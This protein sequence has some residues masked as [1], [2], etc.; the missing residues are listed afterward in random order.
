MDCL[1][2]KLRS[3]YDITLAFP[4]R[5]VQNE[6][7]FAS[8]HRPQ[9][10]CFHVRRYDV[11]KDLPPVSNSDELQKWLIDRWREK[12]EELQ[13]F[14]ESDTRRLS[15]DRL[16]PLKPN[17]RQKIFLAFS[18]LFWISLTSLWIY[19]LC[20]F[21]YMWLYVLT[22]T[23]TFIIIGRIFGGIERLE[24]YIWKS[25]RKIA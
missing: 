12:E 1:E 7:Q 20:A 2:K 25:R 10:L 15:S 13:K 19:W 16:R 11:E 6:L 9:A 3:L 24:L 18:S 23:T 22:A 17:D 5:I 21:P 8:G 14:Y 4:D